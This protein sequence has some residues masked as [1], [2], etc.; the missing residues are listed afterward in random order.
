MTPSTI[1]EKNES[2]LEM[3]IDALDKLN[4]ERFIEGIRHRLHDA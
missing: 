1:V 4:E 3:V 2:G